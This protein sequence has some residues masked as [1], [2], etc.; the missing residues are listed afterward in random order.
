[1]KISNH[2]VRTFQDQVKSVYLK[3]ASFLVKTCVYCV[4]QMLIHIGKLDEPKA[5]TKVLVGLNPRSSRDSTVDLKAWTKMSRTAKKNEKRTKE[6][7]TGLRLI[8]SYHPNFRGPRC[9]DLKVMDIMDICI[10]LK[11][12]REKKIPSKYPE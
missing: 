5:R 8:H 7:H 2:L 12:Q 6:I 11:N 1:M 9:V 4:R 3:S 10:S